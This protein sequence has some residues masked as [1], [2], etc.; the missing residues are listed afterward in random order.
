MGHSGIRI[1]SGFDSNATVLH[2][3]STDASEYERLLCASFNGIHIG[4]E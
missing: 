3:L 1:I 2:L 4:V